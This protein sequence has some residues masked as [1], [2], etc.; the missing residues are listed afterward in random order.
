[1]KDWEVHWSTQGS[2]SWKTFWREASARSFAFSIKDDFEDVFVRNKKYP[3]V[4]SNEDPPGYWNPN[5]KG[6]KDPNCQH[7]IQHLSPA[8]YSCRKC[9]AAYRYMCGCGGSMYVC[10]YHYNEIRDRIEKAGGLEKWF[11]ENAW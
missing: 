3:R 8:M 2:G 6:P 11:A 10:S 1:M 9:G 5:P 7:E 4:S